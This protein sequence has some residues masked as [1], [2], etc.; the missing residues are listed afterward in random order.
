M[1]F[2]PNLGQPVKNRYKVPKKTWNKWSNFARRVFNDV[3]RSFRP[4]L[5]AQLNHPATPV[6]PR[7]QWKTIQWNA[8]WLAAYA[9]NG[10][11]Y[12]AKVIEPKRK[13]RGK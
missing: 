4:A 7:E 12:L 3:Y 11:G 6:M 2:N 9:A 10:R 5:Q 13:R 8:A 1:P